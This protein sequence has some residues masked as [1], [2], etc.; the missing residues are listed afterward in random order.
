M[1]VVHTPYYY[2]RKYGIGE[3]QELFFSN[4]ELQNEIST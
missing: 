2:I 3:L 1:Y 4:H